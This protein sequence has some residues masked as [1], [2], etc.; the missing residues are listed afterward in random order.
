MKWRMHRDNPVQ[1]IKPIPT[2]RFYLHQFNFYGYGDFYYTDVVTYRDESVAVYAI[3]FKT[4]DRKEIYKGKY[5]TF[6]LIDI[7]DSYYCLIKPTYHKNKF[8]VIKWLKDNPDDCEKI[9]DLMFK[10]TNYFEAAIFDTTEGKTVDSPDFC[11]NYDHRFIVLY[12]IVDG[13]LQ[14]KCIVDLRKQ[15]LCTQQTINDYI[16]EKYIENNSHVFKRITPVDHYIELADDIYRNTHVEIERNIQHG[17]NQYI[18]EIMDYRN[19]LNEILHKSGLI[20]IPELNTYDKFI[21]FD[22]SKHDY[23][24][25]LPCHIKRSVEF[26]EKFK[27]FLINHF[28]S[29]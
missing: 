3:D 15:V 14:E 28:E 26:T 5:P 9:K 2:F 4:G 22:N 11:L 12:H 19:R 29:N 25:I 20:T 27:L 7:K 18:N 13:S 16:F 10:H 17:Y 21:L 1:E 8:D 6:D 23:K 24:S